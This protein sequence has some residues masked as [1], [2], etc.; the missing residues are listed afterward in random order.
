MDSC[1]S[2]FMSCHGLLCFVFH[3]VA[4]S[5]EAVMSCHG[6]LCFVFHVVAWSPEAV[7]VFC[8]CLRAMVFCALSFMSWHG[9]L[10]LSCRAMVFC[11]L[12]FMSWHGLLKLS[13]RAMV[14]CALS[15]MSWHGLLCFVFHIVLWSPCCA[16]HVVPL[17]SVL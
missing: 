4:W 7:M 5:P 12:S 13:C 17:S 6:L 11:A 10:K 8:V 15:F 9:L 3:V 2:A 14:F 1:A 16:F